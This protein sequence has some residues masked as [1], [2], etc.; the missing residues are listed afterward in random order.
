MLAENGEFIVN[1]IGDK[2][3]IGWVCDFWPIFVIAFSCSLC[4]TWLCKKLAIK[5]NIVDKPDLTVKTHKEPI[6]YLGGI[7][8]LTGFAVAILYGIYHQY[9]ANSNKDPVIMGNIIKW[10][11]GILAGGTIAC[12]VGV[13]DDVIDLAPKKKLL[14]QLLAACMLILVSIYPS[15][16]FLHNLA[17]ITVADNIEALIGIPLTIMFVLGATNSLNLL[18]G[19]DGLCAGV[20]VIITLAMLFLAVHLGTYGSNLEADPVRII[21][22]LALVG[23]V[24]GFMPFNRHPAKIFMGDAG[25]MLLGFVVAAMMLMFAQFHPRW[26]LAAL[27]VFGLPILDTATALVRRFMNKRPLL[28]SDRGHLYDQ[29]M[30]RGYSLKKTVRICYALS[31]IFAIIG[32]SMS[33]IPTRFAICFYVLVFAASALVIWKKGFLRMEGLRGAVKKDTKKT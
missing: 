13:I 32:V 14:G 23:G 22:C 16:G 19:L 27:V 9:H 20:T 25:S 3:S 6:A 10:L 29:L 8:I 24:L 4:A 5:Y 28:I 18:D 2:Q 1:F 30:D 26:M 7:G 11:L 33:L 31:A 21:V 17:G 12:V 15:L